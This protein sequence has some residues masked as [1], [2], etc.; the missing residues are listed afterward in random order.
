ML[1]GLPKNEVKGKDNSTNAR[2][3][4]DKDKDK[5]KSKTSTGEKIHQSSNQNIWGVICYIL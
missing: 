1:S 4:K 5:N 2:K 3:D